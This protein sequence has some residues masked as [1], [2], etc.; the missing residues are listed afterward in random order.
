MSR[1]DAP[2]TETDTDTDTDSHEVDAEALAEAYNRGLACERAGDVDGAA[3]AFRAALAIDPADRGGVSVRLAALG[4]AAAPPAAPPAYV[5][6]L[7][8]QHAARFDEILVDQ[9][10][11][12]APLL[13]RDALAAAGV[14]E[15]GALLDLGCGTG[16]FGEAMAGRAAR[17]VGVDLS[18]NMLAL[19]HEKDAY[20]ALYLGEA[21]AF[22]A[23]A[24]GDDEDP[25]LPAVFDVIAALDVLPYLG[26][27]EGLF[28]G[29]AARL[30]PGGSAV[31]SSEALGAGAGAD[32]AVGPKHRFA[33]SEAYLRRLL[34][35]R[36][37]T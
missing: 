3:A 25:D 17:A 6:T 37:L 23:E 7:F 10:G 27:L 31:F 4:R 5:A 34:A 32:W 14:G 1:E 35:E 12:S 21:V 24:E 20:D 26:A 29:V 9:L 2:D 16:L 30:A 8:D 28:D 33:H 19:A 11:Y 36:G 15:I 22:L 18:E 13:A